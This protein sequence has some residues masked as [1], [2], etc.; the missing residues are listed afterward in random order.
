MNPSAVPKIPA[1][2]Y[3]I[4]LSGSGGQGMM[5]IAM[6]LCEAVGYISRLN[7][8][9]TKS[10][11]PEARGGA[12]KADIVISPKEIYYPKPLNLDFLL[13]MTQESLDKY[14]PE[15][16]S[17]GILILDETLVTKPPDA[18]YYSLPF[19]QMARDEV[20]NTMVANVISLGATAAIT[21]MVTH[22]AL[23]RTVLARAPKG[24]EEKNTHALEIGFREGTRLRQQQ[25]YAS[26]PLPPEWL[27]PDNYAC[28]GKEG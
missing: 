1:V 14:Y 17:D 10:Y 23:T 24:T 28:L 26:M 7:I 5:L 3:E 13:V 19:T 25:R 12:S 6:L 27:L 21:G 22:D 20:Q 16:K 11:G 9:Q 8:V 18:L 2:R 15:L 4:R